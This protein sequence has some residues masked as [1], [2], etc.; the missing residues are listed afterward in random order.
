MQ[1]RVR[2]VIAQVERFMQT[3]DDALALPRDAAEFM[4]AL[5]LATGARRAVEI[6]TS[7]GYSGLWIAAALAE[8]GGRLITIDRLDHKTEAARGYF[9]SAGLDHLVAFRTGP[10]V[11]VLPTI[12]GPVDFVLNDADKE[13]CR[14]YVEILEDRL[15]NLAVVLTDNILSHKEELADFVSWIRGHASFASALVPVG[16]GME[17]SVRRNRM[18]V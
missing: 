17:L 11:D 8:N 2:D 15:S 12:T 4:H 3:A 16:S 5:V 13:N 14:R 6:G 1:S 18:R 7:Y 10:A 9:R